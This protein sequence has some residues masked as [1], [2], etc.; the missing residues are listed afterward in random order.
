M[1]K[2]CVLT[3]V[4]GLT[5][6]SYVPYY[7]Y[8]INQEYPDYDVLIYLDKPLERGCKHQIELLECFNYTIKEIDNSKIGLS[9]K[10]FNVYNI[11]RGTRWLLFDKSLLEYEAIYIGD[12]DILICKEQ[13]GLYEQ[14]M[15]H[16]KYLK[17]P[18][19]N[20]I[21]I[22][23]EPKTPR[24]FVVNTKEYG[25]RQAYQT[26]LFPIHSWYR[27][28]GL[29]FIL[30]KGGYDQLE[31]GIRSVTEELN[32]VAENKSHTW[33]V[34]NINDESI[35]FELI[36][37][38]GIGLPPL[39]E[40]EEDMAIGLKVLDNTNPETVL[41]RPHHGLHL[42]LWRGE[43]TDKELAL[44]QAYL[45]YYKDFERKYSDSPVLRTLCENNSDVASKQIQKMMAFYKRYCM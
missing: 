34:C 36:S 39:P 38:S 42:A 29:H 5:Y 33:T 30:T 15:K 22:Y 20:C 44:C 26:L 12:V 37:R 3:Y 7:I 10:A 21:R 13:L 31:R 17:L 2:C 23:K 16:A 25:L 8:F 14:H 9:E 19:S 11:S 41:F 35:L 27:L 45:N 43:K 18:Y 24:R 40:H 32:M 1:K 4:F 6:Q 28:T